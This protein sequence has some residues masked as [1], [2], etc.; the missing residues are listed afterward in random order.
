MG[1]CDSHAHGVDRTLS[2]QTVKNRGSELKEAHR[3]I[4]TDVPWAGHDE[5]LPSESYTASPRHPLAEMGRYRPTQQFLPSSRS[6][7][8]P[9][10]CLSRH[11]SSERPEGAWRR[12]AA[13]RSLPGT[14]GGALRLPSLLQA[15]SERREALFL[16]LSN[17]WILKTT[18]RRPQ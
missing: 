3:H 11:Q 5:E 14:R 9:R 1:A 4:H 12:G 8:R 16:G 18:Q 17:D 15:V 7:N 13:M 6:W 2:I 10:P